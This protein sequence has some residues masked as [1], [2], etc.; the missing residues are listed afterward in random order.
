[1]VMG[2]WD[3]IDQRYRERKKKDGVSRDEPAGTSSIAPEERFKNNQE[4]MR[5]ST[6][7][8]RLANRTPERAEH[9]IA[10]L[11]KLLQ[12]VEPNE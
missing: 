4:V 10:E 5:L 9:I 2:K 7:L 12:D 11:S 3:D 1:M 6:E 8:V